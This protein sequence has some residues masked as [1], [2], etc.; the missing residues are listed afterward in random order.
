MKA[1][2][3]IFEIVSE[4]VESPK[5][6]PCACMSVHMSTRVTGKV[7]YLTNLGPVIAVDAGQ[8]TDTGPGLVVPVND[9]LE[10]S[11][12]ALLSA[13]FGI[14]SSDPLTVGTLRP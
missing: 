7:V 12:S 14:A 3:C 8:D 1:E 11:D 10:G 2:V 13:R 9:I 6:W 4:F 5:R